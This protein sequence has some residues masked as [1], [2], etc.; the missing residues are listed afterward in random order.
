MMRTKDSTSAPW[1]ALLLALLLASLIACQRSAPSQT[2]A[3]ASALPPVVATVNGRAI[4]SR[5]YEMYLRNGQEALGIDPTSEEG[6][7]KL[8]L[9]KE[10]IVSELID[11]TLIAQEAERRGLAIAPEKLADA[12][13]KTIAQFGGDEKYDKYLAQHR[14]TRDEYRDVIKT[15][16]YGG[17][18]REEL[19]KGLTVSGEEVK[20]YY[21]AHRTD[22]D[23]QQPERVKA[24]HILI[25]ARPN[26]IKQDVEREKGLSGEALNRAVRE[27]M[28]RRRT[29][30]EELR[31]KAAGG[32]DFA[33]LARENS[34][35]PSSREQGGDLG[36]FTRDSHPRAFDDAAFALKPGTVSGVVQT[37]FGYHVIKLFSHEPA[38]AKTLQEATEEI[39]QRLKA[40]REAVEL[41]NFLRETRRKAT[42]RINEPFRFGKLKDEF[43]AM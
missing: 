41:T 22:P 1:R 38:R 26:L 21:L 19:S 18:M 4:Q 8:E 6:R 39:T 17:L 23:M 25:A 43:T 10:G 11:R 40:Q 29:R 7:R 13:R 35:D 9:L 30:A 5:L 2:N 3:N 28:E 16:I 27:E 20:A 15:E 31:R 36:S 34:D 14:L 37:D 33:T 32:A 12:E 24:S 42:V